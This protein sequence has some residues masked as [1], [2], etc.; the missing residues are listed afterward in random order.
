MPRGRNYTTSE[1]AI[2]ILGLRAGVA[3]FKINQILTEEQKKLGL[4][5]RKVPASSFAIMKAKYLPAMDDKEIWYYIQNPK[6]IG[7]LEK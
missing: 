1:R 7:K 5:E 6:S 2:I 3:P 4:T